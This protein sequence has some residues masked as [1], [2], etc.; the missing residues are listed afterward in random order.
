MTSMTIF[1]CKGHGSMVHNNRKF[2]TENVD[3]KWI[4]DNIT[5]KAKPIEE[6]YQK[7]FDEKVKRY[8]IGKN[9]V[10][11]YLITWSR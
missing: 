8:N 9:L 5:Y 7:L 1:V 4:Q 2:V 10:D 11:R 6:S 3:K